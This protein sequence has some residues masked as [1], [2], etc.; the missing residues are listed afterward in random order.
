MGA[1]LRYTW[2][3]QLA[4]RE[5]A[6]IAT[7]HTCSD[8][9]ETL[10]FGRRGRDR[11][12]TG[13]VSACRGIY[14]RPCLSLTRADTEAYSAALGQTMCRMRPTPPTFLRPATASA[15]RWCRRCK[16][17]PGGGAGDRPPVPPDA[18]TG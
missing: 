2:F 9:A 10:L 15:T 1:E 18:G 5:E 16:R 7:A 11:A 14:R 6:L 17:Q 13:Q 12:C 8:Q 3:D 4:A